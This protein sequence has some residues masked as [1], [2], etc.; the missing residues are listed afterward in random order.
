MD[1]APKAL[2]K[3]VRC[4]CKMGCDALRCFCSKAGLDCSTGCGQYRICVNMYDNMTENNEYDEE[5]SVVI[6]LMQYDITFLHIALIGTIIW[7]N[8]VFMAAVMSS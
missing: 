1:V 4:S 6:L 7:T 8:N 3:V 5:T 2:L